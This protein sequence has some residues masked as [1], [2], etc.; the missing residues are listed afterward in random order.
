M[1]RGEV[2]PE[3][4]ADQDRTARAIHRRE[5][6]HSR[7]LALALQAQDKVIFRELLAARAKA[8]AGT[9]S[10]S[11]GD[12]QRQVRFQIYR[13]ERQTILDRYDLDGATAL[14]ILA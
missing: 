2:P 13:R 5:L 9:P 12:R 3:V 1:D 14:R 4:L 6:G 7:P 11:H 10:K 8:M